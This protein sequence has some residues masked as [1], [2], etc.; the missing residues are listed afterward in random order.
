M[1]TNSFNAKKML[2]STL[3]AVAFS[4]VF[5]TGG[6]ARTIGIGEASQYEAS[7]C[8]QR[9]KKPSGKWS[10]NIFGLTA[11]IFYSSNNKQSVLEK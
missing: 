4:F 5:T 8:G 2:M 6:N 9:K 3:A 1:K 10:K 7:K 11:N